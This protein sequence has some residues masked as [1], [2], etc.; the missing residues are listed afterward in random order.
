MIDLDNITLAKGSHSNPEAGM[1]LLEA[2]AYV[3]GV[4][5][6]DHPPCV[7]RVLGAFGRSLNDR[8]PAD[9]RQLLVP[10]IP[11]LIGTADDREADRIRGM[12]ATDWAVRTAA[13]TWLRLAGLEAEADSLA[14]LSEL[15]TYADAE[16]ATGLVR[17][18]RDAARKLRSERFKKL[19]AA[20]AAYAAAADA[21][22][23][24]ADAASYVAA[25]YAAAA[26]AADAAYAA[27][28]AAAA[29]AAYAAADAAE[30]ALQPTADRMNDAA[31]DLFSRMIDVRT[32]K[33]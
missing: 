26:A 10:L 5:F 11:R 32:E 18:V 24:A 16:T 8:L 19:P 29:A 30:K 33:P 22:S 6:T 27:A 9:K 31:I 4:E 15:K 20:A 23:Y 14:G 3:R 1:C 13:P 12:M 17:Q 2:V 21:A 7:S 28:Y 25:S